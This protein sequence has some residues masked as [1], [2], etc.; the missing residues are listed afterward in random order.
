MVGDVHGM[1]DEL[2]HQMHDVGFMP[3]E[4]RIFCVGDLVDFGAGS[5]RVVEILNIP[6]V[7]S[8]RGYR[9]QRLLSLY[10]AGEIDEEQA[11]YHHYHDGGAWWTRL[12]TF[13]RKHVLCRLAMLPWAIEIET[14]RGL[15]GLLHADAPA[16]L[17]WG[18]VRNRLE[19]GDRL[20]QFAALTGTARVTAQDTSGIE[21]VYRMFVGHTL[22]RNGPAELGNVVMLDTGAVLGSKT[23]SGDY[24]LT[25]MELTAAVVQPQVRESVRESASI[26]RLQPA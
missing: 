7:H 26:L 2:L 1:F 6:G 3:G 15:V 25:M 11:Q 8:I 18:D 23:S 14:E 19:R 21:G 17:S 13:E 4:D 12:R 5:S 9:E 10:G 20:V 22:T 24:G 16:G